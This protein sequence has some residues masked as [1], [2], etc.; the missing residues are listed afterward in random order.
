MALDI[1]KLVFTTMN[2]WTV[3]VIVCVLL[4]QWWKKPHPR[5]P[6]G[7]RGIPILGA[8]P[9]VDVYMERTVK[10]WSLDKYGPV[11][12]V[13]MGQKEVVFLNTYEAINQAFVKQSDCFSG[14]S[15]VVMM[16]DA[17]GMNGL[18][19]KDHDSDFKIQKKFAFN[20]LKQSGM[21]K[22]EMENFVNIEAQYFVEFLEKLPEKTIDLRLD[23]RNLIANI[24]CKFVLG[25][26]YEYDDT[27]F[28][29]LLESLQ[30]ELGKAD[31][32]L[33]VVILEYIPI[34]S[35]FQPFKGALKQ[36][37]QYERNILAVLRPIV[38][39]H[40]K[41][42]VKTDIKDYIDA[43]LYEQKYGSSMSS[44]TD[45]QLVIC[46]RDLY[47]AGTETS[48]GIIY[49]ALLGLLHHP[50]YYEK[51]VKEIDLILGAD[52]IPSMLLKNDM[53]ITRAFIQEILRY[54]VALPVGIPHRCQV[55]TELF[56]YHIPAGTD[57]F[58]NIWGVHFDP[59]TWKDPETF[60]PSR[61]IDEEGKFKHSSKIIP[62]AIGPRACLGEGLAR[63]EVFLIFIKLL[64]TFK[65]SA[66]TD[67]LPSL[68]RGEQS[69]IYNANSFKVNLTSR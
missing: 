56:G 66:A 69:L 12:S 1:L 51:I 44:F 53:P 45:E 16:Y 50:D 11:M 68:Y 52:K 3:L 26:R 4:W 31:E 35:K 22:S 33:K 20:Y 55:D 37:L 47:V 67:P 14:R 65:I 5:F 27:T 30:D 38:E 49:F 17:L 9:F 6:P 8:L 39:E 57:V 63:M 43:Y 32:T 61:H 2:L 13:R 25:K 28:R 10:K 40:K 62:F 58:A 24:I 7:P 23:L 54:C 59:D 42:F 36:H 18:I 21:G 29:K 15:K 34:L 48:S 41:T 64:Q 46:L 19:M 60:D